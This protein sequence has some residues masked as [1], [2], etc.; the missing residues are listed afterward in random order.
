MGFI[1]DTKIK[2][3]GLERRK[4]S[5]YIYELGDKKENIF[6]YDEDGLVEISKDFLK[7]LLKYFNE[8][9]ELLEDKKF[10]SKND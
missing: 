6:V 1:I 3:L 2:G 9:P 7:K 8:N 4:D 5:F 10:E